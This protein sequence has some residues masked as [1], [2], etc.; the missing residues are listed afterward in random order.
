[1]VNLE[2]KT[3][4]IEYAFFLSKVIVAS[5]IYDSFQK[6]EQVFVN[7][8]YFFV[9]YQFYRFSFFIYVLACL[10]L[11]LTKKP[12]KISMVNNFIFGLFHVW[13]FLFLFFH[14]GFFFK[15][16]N[17]RFTEEIGERMPF[18]VWH[19]L[20]GLVILKTH[21]FFRAGKKIFEV[22]RRVLRRKV[23]E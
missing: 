10:V 11:F 6:N 22:G 7:A 4:L 19:Y 9:L 18:V 20:I 3:T 15:L 1:M 5:F 8:F 2:N 21:W 17:N 16:L 23:K 12:D 13:F 14:L